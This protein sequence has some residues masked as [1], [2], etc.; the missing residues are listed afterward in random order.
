[1][2]NR[3]L[4][5]LLSIFAPLAACVS[6]SDSVP[7]SPNPN[8]T[9]VPYYNPLID[10]GP[11]P[12]DLYF[13]H[14]DGSANT[15]GT[16]SILPIG[17]STAGANAPV[18]ALDHLDGFGTQAAITV[19]FSQPVDA[20]TLTPA[21]VLVFK[22]STNPVNKAIN[23]PAPAGTGSATPLI[24]GT[25]YSV[26]LSSAT[27]AN[28]TIVNITPLKPLASGSSYL[29][30]M[31]N[32][33][34]DKAGIAAAPSTSYAAILAADLPVLAGHAMG[35]TGN[36]TLDQ[37][38]LFTLPQIIVASGVVNPT[39][40]ILTFSFSTQYAGVT[41]ATMEA[42]AAAT[43]QPAGV[44][45]IDTNLTVS[46]ALTAAGQTPPAVAA[47]AELYAGTVALPYYSAVAANTHD[48]APL[49]GFWHNAAGGDT[50]IS[51]NPAVSELPKATVAQNVIPILVAIPDASSGC[52]MP[53]SG[54]PVVIFQ[55]GITRN[56]EDMLA[57]A[58]TF[59][60]ACFAT[61]AID[62]PLHGVTSTTDPLY[63]A[64]HERTFNLDLENNT[65]G[66][67]APDGV[68][69]PSGT[70][71]I[72]LSS[73]LTSRDNLREG[74]ADLINLVATLPHL[75]AVHL[76]AT[77]N[78]F[79]GSKIFF[80][81]HSLG[82]IVGTTFLGVDS[83]VVAATLA[84]PG[85]KVSALLQN[86][87]TFSPVINAG[88]QAEGITPGT[89]FY[90]D[91]LNYAQAAV[92]DGDP[93]NYA[94]AAAAHHPIHMLEVIGGF[95]SDPCNVA[96]TVVP[97]SATDLLVSLMGLTQVH[98]TTPGSHFIVR[99][100]AGDHGSILNPAAPSTACAADA[101]LYGGV[102]VEMQTETA[103]FVGS[104]GTVVVIN[105]TPA[106]VIQ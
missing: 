35:T 57:I 54:W 83:H 102:T 18:A 46:Q 23:P 17:T 95:G 19:T 86:S 62:L 50:V 20:T 33:V 45:I 67:A 53:V 30:I 39:N 1:M 44:G 15:T 60:S 11:F 85:G 27:D 42:A 79:D 74:A 88:L 63:I 58:G 47:L 3:R 14:S 31:T 106:G 51:G 41:L 66:A 80:V 32:G 22:V 81:G 37:V 38:A 68:I 105:D 96:D 12:N 5:A 78:T 84:S 28:G 2:I 25:D 91:F 100:T 94:I 8:S 64:G 13:N 72:N 104:G 99:F 92:D 34:K 21:T 73:T 43:T 7:P 70:W 9:F 4:V 16:L 97:N 48:T 26:G 55:H 36:A 101:L 98:T 59:A 103:N 6:A 24:P 71:F 77:L 10:E 93:G 61:V 49:T 40:L 65:T 52:S 90:Y 82:G 75:A 76:P 69:D 56:R 87:P 89:Q 29:V